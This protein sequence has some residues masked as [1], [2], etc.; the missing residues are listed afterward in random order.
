[1]ANTAEQLV[2]EE[3]PSGGIGG[4]V[5]P[6][7]D[8]E[9]LERENAA[10]EFG[11]NGIAEFGSVAAKMAGYGRFGDD[12][13]VHVETGE[14]VVPRK[15]IEQSPE[16]RESIFQHLR[17]AGIEDPERYVVGSAENSI[18]PETGLMEFGFFKKIFKGIG[19]VF[20]SVGKILKK[21][22]PAILAVG[23]TT[24]FPLMA[25]MTVGAI[26]GGIGTLL[27]GGSI[28]SAFK[29]ALLGGAAGT[30][31]SGFQ[32]AKAAASGEKL[33]GA[34]K[35]IKQGF[36]NPF[37]YSPPTASLLETSK[38][39]GST[40]TPPTSVEAAKAAAEVPGLDLNTTEAQNFLRGGQDLVATPGATG[41][42]GFIGNL[43]EAAKD[44]VSLDFG[45]VGTNLKEAFFPSTAGL[46]GFEKMMAY[47]PA[48]LTGAY[49]GGAFKKPEQEEV[50]LIE[51]FGPTAQ[52]RLEEEPERYRVMPNYYRPYTPPR[53]GGTLVPSTNLGMEPETEAAEQRYI[54]RLRGRRDN[55][56]MQYAATG[57]EVFPRRSGGIMPDEGIPNEDSVRAMLT[58]GEFV[59]TTDAVR[60]AGNGNVSQGIKNM[61]T[62]MRDLERRGGAMS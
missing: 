10:Q 55:F 18:N 33:S 26:S 39:T 25:P 13:V 14:L 27:Q 8:F 2:V 15:L 24:M 34:F 36:T 48:L 22:A 61:Y 37:S 38:T 20:K 40:G 32:G 45:G 16:L 7:E 56:G 12:Q 17:D 9:I 21:A 29:S 52:E 47:T 53:R 49:L 6:D 58:P 31:L 41:A 43:G 62:V 60:G 57:G 11:A 28:K 19:K 51:Q 54:P 46:G 30:A 5:M 23:L 50:G 4:F 1:M 59:M 42:T 3:V 44:L 35:N